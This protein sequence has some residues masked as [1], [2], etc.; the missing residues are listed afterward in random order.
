M[1]R[2]LKTERE[3]HVRVIGLDDGRIELGVL[4]ENQDAL[5]TLTPDERDQIVAWLE[6][7]TSVLAVV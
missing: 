6:N 3:A 1:D 7:P 4:S 5:A 2:T